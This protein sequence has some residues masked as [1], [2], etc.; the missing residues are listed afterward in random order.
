MPTVDLRAP[1]VNVDLQHGDPFTLNVVSADGGEVPETLAVWIALRQSAGTPLATL[2]PSS[3]VLGRSFYL[4]DE[5]SLALSPSKAYQLVARDSDTG[6]T[7]FTGPVK[8][9][10]EGAPG[11]TSQTVT[12]ALSEVSVTVELTL[13][14]GGGGSAPTELGDLTDVD[15]NPAPEVDDVLAWDGEVWAPATLEDNDELLTAFEALVG[16]E[17]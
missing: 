2:T 13:A 17:E 9:S 8:P 4:S 7:W 10:T 1:Q 14:A 5:A 6:I 15:L 11:P 3:I 12:V 16:P